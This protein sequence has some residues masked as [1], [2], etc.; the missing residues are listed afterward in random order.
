M[1]KPNTQEGLANSASCGN[2]DT[3]YKEG[4]LRK[5]QMIAALHPDVARVTQK[6]GR[7]HHHVDYRPFRKN[8]L[9]RKPGLEIKQGADE[10]GMKLV[11]VA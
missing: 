6:F 9:V 4:V 10:Y 5:A 2:T 3:I 1:D 8:K 7:W 11:Q